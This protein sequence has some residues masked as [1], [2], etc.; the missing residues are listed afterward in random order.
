M[1]DPMKKD[2]EFGSELRKRATPEFARKARRSAIKGSIFLIAMGVACAAF[3]IHGIPTGEI[4][5]GTK[6]GS[7]PL[8][9]WEMAGLG[10]VLIAFGVWSLVQ[11]MRQP[12]P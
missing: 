8:N 4:F 2:P 9:G 7:L 10:F 12:K 11:D 3:G 1:Y 6:A 5:H